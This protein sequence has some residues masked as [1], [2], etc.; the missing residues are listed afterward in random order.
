MAQTQHFYSQRKL[1]SQKESCAGFVLALYLKLPVA[2]SSVQTVFKDPTVKHS[3]I[4]YLI[5]ALPDIVSYQ[6]SY[7]IFGLPKSSLQ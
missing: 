6:P 4:K 7:C 2:L 3:I 5:M 1:I